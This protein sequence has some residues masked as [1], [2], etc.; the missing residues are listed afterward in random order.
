MVGF[1]E[2]VGGYICPHGVYHIRENG[3]LTAMTCRHPPKNTKAVTVGERL[4]FEEWLMA[5]LLGA[6][7]PAARKLVTVNRV[8]GLAQG[9]YG[10]FTPYTDTWYV[11]ILNQIRS[12]GAEE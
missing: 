10:T 12:E 4:L 8:L 7:H 11:S 5:K 2:T 1:E 6:H 9:R 3:R